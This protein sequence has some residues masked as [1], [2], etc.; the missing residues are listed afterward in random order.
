MGWGSQAHSW[1][2]PLSL[3]W[4]GKN[5]N[6][7]EEPGRDPAVHLSGASMTKAI[8][9]FRA[10]WDSQ[11]SSARQP[12]PP[13]RPSASGHFYPFCSTELW[14]SC[15][16]AAHPHTE[17]WAIAPP[18]PD[19]LGIPSAPP[20]HSIPPGWL[21]SAQRQ[22][23]SQGRP[24]ERSHALTLSPADSCTHRPACSLQSFASSPG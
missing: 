6:A 3:H 5:Q 18:Q 4:K 8:H 22:Q 13:S 24:Q 2:P 11:C 15:S 17:H 1:H 20:A 10:E 7:K 12:P 21:R 19:P 16:R 14:G 9:H 23:D